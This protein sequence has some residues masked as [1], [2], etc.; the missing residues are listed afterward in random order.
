VDVCVVNS[1][2]LY[3]EF[4]KKSSHEINRK[5]H[6]WWHRIFFHFVDVCVVNSYILYKEFLKKS[7]HEINRKS[8]KWWHRI[9]FHFVDVCVVNSY[10][11][12]KLQNEKIIITQ[13]D[14]RRQV[15]DGLVAEKLVSL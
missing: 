3:K 2:I 9:F 1:Y 15:V 11:L 6:K 13:K 14:F 12:Y 5:S 8:H 10:I 7:S 4:L